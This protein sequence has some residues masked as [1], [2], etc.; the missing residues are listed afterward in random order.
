MPRG[1]AGVERGRLALSGWTLR[2]RLKLDPRRDDDEVE[3]RALAGAVAPDAHRATH[4]LRQLLADDQAQARAAVL[5]AG[6]VVR[7]TEAPEQ[8]GDAGLAQ[9]DAAVAHLKA[10]LVLHA[11]GLHGQHDL[12]ALGELDRVRE[13]VP[14]DL[15]EPCDVAVQRR[16]H[17]LFKHRPE[18][19][20]FLGRASTDQIHGCLL[21]TSPS[22]RDR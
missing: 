1:H 16:G 18:R 11:G 9:A 2:I 15:T 13:K 19:Q 20:S 22:P 3:G 4:Q 10:E 14:Q 17:A 8:L 12:P 21:Y 5:A 7:L 6:R